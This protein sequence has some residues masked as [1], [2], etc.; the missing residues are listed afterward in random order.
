MKASQNG[1]TQNE[2]ELDKNRC[3]QI[4]DDFGE[5]KTTDTHSCFYLHAGGVIIEFANI[6]SMRILHHQH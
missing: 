2:F 3:H 1:K 6:G 5:S 4:G